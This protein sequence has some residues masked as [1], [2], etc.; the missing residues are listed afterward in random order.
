MPNQ[1]EPATEPNDL[2]RFFIARA[3]AGDLEGLVILFEPEAVVAR[4]DGGS[5]RG[6][7]AIRDKYA[8]VLAR[9]PQFSLGRQQPAM[10]NGDIA[11]TCTAFAGGGAAAEVARRQPDGTWLWI[12]DKGSIAEAEAEA[13][14]EARP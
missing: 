8:A 2:A 6:H 14:A 12:I 13:E 9:R 5:V 1:H 3:N 7:D 11:L 10:I 4:F